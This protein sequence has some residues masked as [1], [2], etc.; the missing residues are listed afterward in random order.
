MNSVKYS[1]YLKE[2]SKDY[3]YIDFNRLNP[4]EKGERKAI[5]YSLK[6]LVTILKP[7]LQV[8]FSDQL[9][10]VVPIAVYLFFF[11]I[12]LFKQ[13]V[14][15]SWTITLGLFGVVLGLMFFME[16]LKVGLM[17]F[18]ENIG[19][20]LPIKA[21]KVLVFTIAF[22][23]GVGATLAE[24]AI[25]ILKE[26]GKIVD[27]VRNP[28]LFSMLNQ[29]SGYTVAAVAAGVGAATLLGILMFVYGWKLRTLIYLTV[30]P[31]LI[32]TIYSLS[33]EHLSGVIGLAWDC[34][35]VTTGPVT[36]PLV[37]SLGVGMGGVIK[38]SHTRT[39]PGFGIVTLASMF[40]I[41]SVLSLALVLNSTVS[42][43]E[44]RQLS[45]PSAA[46]PGVGHLTGQS[47][48]LA[49]RAVIPLAVFLFCVQ[50][51]ILHEP[52]RQAG[53][54][55]YGICLCLAGMAVFN[56][57]LSFGLTPLGN[58]VG[59]VVPAS[60][61]AIAHVAHS[62]LY[63]RAIGLVICLIFAF[64]LGYIATLAEPALNAFGIT[65][66]NLTNG[67]F[68]KN[69]VMVTV[70]MGVSLGIA[71]GVLKIIF[72]VPLAMLVVPFYFLVLILTAISDDKYVNMG[73]DSAGVTTG[74]I[75]VPLVLAMGLGFAGAAQLM[76]GFGI[77]AL[78]SVFPIISFLCV[79]IYLGYIEK[80]NLEG[81]ENA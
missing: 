18:G 16:G 49:F 25:G 62:P 33:D 5:K 76:D 40:P 17:P 74:P 79:G 10:V 67:A 69:L 12:V 48:L 64:F 15:G 8:R 28:L 65:V 72:D 26:A 71:A 68:R 30:T 70:S 78:A 22:V 13:M 21:G 19:Y 32:L 73:W 56:L 52:L 46:P 61:T 38:H 50:K 37:L 58:Q 29:F 39:I 59:S 3:R 55:V 7:Y 51:W 27:P 75:T 44:M 80:K 34:G 53:I 31:T 47:V 60:Y 66:E 9:R 42:L 20:L 57:G 43:E 36:V 11:Q 24:P 23:L 54:I 2:T 63:Q 77:L 81:T 41:F 1:Q 35:A 14:A 4:R 6:N 45:E